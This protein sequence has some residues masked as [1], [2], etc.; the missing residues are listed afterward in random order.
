MKIKSI[1]NIPIA[2]ESR[3]AKTIANKQRSSSQSMSGAEKG[4]KIKREQ[5]KENPSTFTWVFLI[6][7]DSGHRAP[8]ICLLHSSSSYCG[9]ESEKP[10]RDVAVDLMVY[11]IM[12]KAEK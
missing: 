5:E 3:E 11:T 8:G 4:E 1:T 10:L 12:Q 2:D 6:S 7:V 9:L